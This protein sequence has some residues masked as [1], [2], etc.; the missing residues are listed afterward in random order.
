MLYRSSVLLFGVE[1]RQLFLY[2]IR[3]IYTY[4]YGLGGG[5]TRPGWHPDRGILVPVLN[6]LA[7]LCHGVLV[8]LLVL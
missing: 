3:V 7:G 5:L 8:R 1:T 4:Q 6:S 2:Q